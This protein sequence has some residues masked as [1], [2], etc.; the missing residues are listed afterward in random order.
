M[1]NKIV[2]FFS[3]AAIASLAL[4]LLACGSGPGA[5]R[6]PSNTS[7][8]SSPKPVKGGSIS[9]R[10]ASPPTTFNYL[11]AEDE[12][13][14]QMSQYLLTSRLM[15]FDHRT[16]KFVPALAESWTASADGKTVD[17][18]LRDGL[19]FSDGQPLTADDVIF[20]LNAIYDERTHAAEFRDAMLV[21]DKPIEARK[22]DE[23]TLQFIFPKAV[24]SPENYIVNIGVLPQHTLKSDLEA[25]K[26]GSAWKINASPASIVT[27]GPFTVAAVK[28]GEFVELASNPNYW[29]TDAS[30][31]RM[32]YIEKLVL[33]VVEDP[34]R[35]YG[36]LAQGSLDIVD[37]LRSADYVQ[38]SK[39]NQN[40][41]AGDAGPG[42]GIDHM[43]FNLNT[44]DPKGKPVGSNVKRRWFEDTR[45][46]R[47][48]AMAVDRDSIA[49]ITL[50]GLATPLSGFVS[51]ANKAWA[52]TGLPKLAYDLA[53]AEKL[54]TEAGFTKNGSPDAPTLKD[55]SGNAVEFSLLVPAENEPR[56]LMATVIQQDMAKLGIK[57][58]VVPVEFAALS[59]KWSKTYDYDAIL[60]G[61]SQGDIEPSSY[62]GF[63]LSSGPLHQWHPGQKEPATDWEKQIDTLF[64]Q[65]DVE[66]DAARR[67]DTFNRIQTIMQEQMPVIPIVA[68]HVPSGASARIGNWSPSGI[69]PYSLWNADELY[70]TK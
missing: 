54:L 63:L 48:V 37:R 12:P 30:G 55:S 43:W 60:M 52:N 8:Q 44:T 18:K 27:S 25:G 19:K 26:L 64:D 45:F 59:D 40:A 23:R 20:T 69:L 28:P 49:T 2:G 47:A 41:K 51:P 56:K 4:A 31:T 42:L 66:R 65:Q 34:D 3:I 22:S 17:V 70:V 7:P 46:R 9:Y 15:D 61:I 35:A 53:G 16:Q 29:K 11:V 68:R 33:R 50:Q 1:R 58:S 6:A 62:G 39:D 10:L 57:M 5:E 13:T 36:E 24:A 32:P 38:L 14:I 67:H 21:D